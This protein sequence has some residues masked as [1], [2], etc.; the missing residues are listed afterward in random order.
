VPLKPMKSRQ[1]KAWHGKKEKEEEEEKT[2]KSERLGKN[3]LQS[4]L[5]KRDATKAVGQSRLEQYPLIDG[6]VVL[7]LTIVNC[8][9]VGL[10]GKWKCP[11]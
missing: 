5:V 8:M 9:E 10:A 3:Y 6:M 11:A 2:S 7:L 4:Y 1:G